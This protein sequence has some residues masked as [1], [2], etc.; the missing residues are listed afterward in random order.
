MVADMPT[1]R[2]RALCALA[3]ALLPMLAQAEAPR[4]GRAPSDASA[5][6]M[7]LPRTDT[8]PTL[9]SAMPA[10]RLQQW[11]DGPTRRSLQEVSTLEADFTPRVPVREVLQ[12]AGASGP[13]A[14]VSPVFRDESGGLRALPGGVLAI[15]QAPLD[16]AAAQRLFN[17]AGVTPVKRITDTMWLLEA[18]IGLPA[19]E[20][21][22]RL[23]DSGLFASV[24]PNWWTPRVRK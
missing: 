8:Q 12:P 5:A 17:Q 20:L 23:H 3:V 24:Q 15:L 22:N 2:V 1:G 18:P 6:V 4:R 11:H 9:K 14:L 21:A 19:L 13:T 10:T 16:D 7:P